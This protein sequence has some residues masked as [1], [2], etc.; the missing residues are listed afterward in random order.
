[1]YDSRDLEL[2]HGSWLLSCMLIVLSVL[3]LV[4]WACDLRSFDLPGRS[5][6]VDCCRLFPTALTA[7]TLLGRQ[8]WVFVYTMSEP[9]DLQCAFVTC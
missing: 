6:P 8:A 1:M 3:H 5:Q 2:R 9:L 7:R 4:F